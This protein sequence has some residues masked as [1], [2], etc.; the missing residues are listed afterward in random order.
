MYNLL[1]APVLSGCQSLILSK[2]RLLER[3]FEVFAVLDNT[4]NS[5]TIARAED[6]RRN[7]G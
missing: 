1:K 7:R 3:D 6:E 4:L 5:W 2:A